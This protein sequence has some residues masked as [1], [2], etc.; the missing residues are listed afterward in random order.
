[1]QNHIFF[2]KSLIINNLKRFAMKQL[3]GVKDAFIKQLEEAT[4]M[5]KL[6]GMSDRESPMWMALQISWS[7]E[8][9]NN[10]SLFFKCSLSEVWM[11]VPC[12]AEE[13]QFVNQNHQQVWD[14]TGKFNQDRIE[15]FLE[16]GDGLSFWTKK[17][18]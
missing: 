5:Y 6:I 15:S 13:K 12:T 2:S 3:E 14:E 7:D 16:T 11:R 4:I 18:L 10:L 1:M 8:E 9:D 17:S